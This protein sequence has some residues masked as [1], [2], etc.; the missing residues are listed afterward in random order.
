MPYLQADSHTAELSFSSTLTCMACCINP[1]IPGLPVVRHE[2]MLTSP[3]TNPRI[4]FTSTS[5][6]EMLGQASI[7]SSTG[8]EQVLFMLQAIRHNVNTLWALCGIQ[9]SW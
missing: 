6:A 2:Q 4:E 3:I 1:A 5:K 8:H 7:H 9:K